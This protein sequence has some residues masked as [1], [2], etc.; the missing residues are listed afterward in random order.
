MQTQVFS[1]KLASSKTGTIR[2]H[3]PDGSAIPIC[4]PIPN[5][6]CKLRTRWPPATA[7]EN[8]VSNF[9]GDDALMLKLV[10]SAEDPGTPCVTMVVYWQSRRWHH[11]TVLDI[12]SHTKN[13]RKHPPTIRVQRKQILLFDLKWRSSYSEMPSYGGV[14]AS[15]GTNCAGS[16]LFALTLG[17]GSFYFPRV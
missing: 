5:A 17:A 2:A 15:S 7:S 9:V 12:D 14:H 13:R 1:A 8:Q 6:H 4:Q 3:G 16:P 11:K 10:C